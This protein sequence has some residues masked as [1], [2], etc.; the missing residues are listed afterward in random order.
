M[1]GPSTIPEVY[2][3]LSRL[4]A[5][6]DLIPLGRFQSWLGPLIA[7]RRTPMIEKAYTEIG[8]GSPIRK[9]SELQASEICKRLDKLSPET[10]TPSCIPPKGLR[11]VSHAVLGFVYLSSMSLL[12]SCLHFVSRDTDDS[13]PQ[14]LRGIP[15]RRSPHRRNVLQTT[16]RRNNPC[17]RIQSVSTILVL[18]HRILIKRTVAV[19]SK[20]RP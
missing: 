12:A 19:Y 10:G 18:H 17:H 15:L 6:G 16:L 3:F 5:D 8:G 14:A 11:C 4:F 13:T 2:D 1:G 20:E 7:R 9:W